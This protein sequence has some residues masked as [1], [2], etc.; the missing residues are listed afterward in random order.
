[1]PL[2]EICKSQR[3]YTTK[4]F[5]E[6][7]NEEFYKNNIT[8]SNCTLSLTVQSKIGCTSEVISHKMIVII[9]MSNVNEFQ[10]EARHI[11]LPLQNITIDDVPSKVESI[12]YEVN[13]STFLSTCLKKNPVLHNFNLS[14]IKPFQVSPVLFK[15]VQVR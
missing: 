10:M 8:I 7:S 3:N 11:S 6:C 2:Q 14:N 4:I 12:T 1:M 15:P 13:K 5:L 9:C